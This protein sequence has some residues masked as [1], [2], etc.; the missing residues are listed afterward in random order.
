MIEILVSFGIV[1][2]AA[3]FFDWL[4][5]PSGTGEVEASNDHGHH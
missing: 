1:V 3:V 2:A 5:R 4:L